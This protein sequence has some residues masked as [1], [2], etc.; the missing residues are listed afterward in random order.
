MILDASVLL[1]IGLCLIVLGYVQTHKQ[2]SRQ[3]S[4]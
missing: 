2:P 3:G 4:S 1:I